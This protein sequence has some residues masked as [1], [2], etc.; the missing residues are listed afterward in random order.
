VATDHISG[1]EIS[2]LEVAADLL[3]AEALRWHA[4][5]LW[6]SDIRRR[7]LLSVDE[8]GTTTVVA[9]F[10][11]FPGGIGFLPSGDVLVVM[12]LTRRL[13]R[14]RPS[15]EQSLH[16]DL[17]GL[18][19]LLL[20]DMVVDSRGG[21]FVSSRGT[22]PAVG[23]RID[24]LIRVDA[25]GAARTVAAGGLDGPNGLALTAGAARLVVAETGGQRLTR[26][27]IEDDGSL[28][29]ASTFADATGCSPDGITLDEV[30]AVWFASPYTSEVV[31]VTESGVTR[32]VEAIDGG[33]P[34]SCT[35][36]GADASTLFFTSVVSKDE[37]TLSAWLFAQD[38]LLAPPT[39]ASIFGLSVDVPG[40]GSP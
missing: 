18:A 3:F 34:T 35:L 23:E 4:G 36:G 11:D 30:G 39:S 15:G 1:L 28:G 19:G 22:S 13:L 2:R 16:C 6:F 5:R 8:I 14:V 38:P 32:R 7:A 12:M 29:P 25:D 27:D 24:T 40:T 21:A 31:R 20:S 26:F 17:S 33:H 37:R 9:E 10:D